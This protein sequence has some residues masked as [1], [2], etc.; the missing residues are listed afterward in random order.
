MLIDTSAESAP[1]GIVRLTTPSAEVT[2]APCAPTIADPGPPLSTALESTPLVFAFVLEVQAESWRL[3]TAAQNARKCALGRTARI[4]ILV[5]LLQV[6]FMVLVSRRCGDTSPAQ[7]RAIGI[8]ARR[9]PGD[10][11]RRSSR[12]GSAPAAI[13][14]AP[15]HSSAIRVLRAPVS[16]E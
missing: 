10:G 12:G 7:A 1:G 4:S 11:L 3:A 15:R 16:P 13:A 14:S 9:A 5:V 8:G 2:V 6:P